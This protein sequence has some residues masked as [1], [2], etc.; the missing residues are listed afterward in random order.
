M[1][2]TRRA[3]LAAL[4][5]MPALARAADRPAGILIE[6]ARAV[7]TSPSSPAGAVY[8]RIVN[9]G[10]KDDRLVGVRTSAAARAMLHATETSDGIARMRHLDDG[11]PLPAGG[12]AVLAPGGDHIMLMGLSRPLADGGT[13]TVTLVFAVAGELTIDVPVRIGPPAE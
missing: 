4:A 2:L 6:D 13:L 1:T 8:M 10:T 3:A 5:L 9:Q 11:I 7:A 12:T